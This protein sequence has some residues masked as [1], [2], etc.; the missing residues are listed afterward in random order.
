MSEETKPRGLFKRKRKPKDPNKAPGRLAQM[1][2]IFVMAQKQ[3]PQTAWLMGAAILGGAALGVLVGLI[4][5]AMWLWVILGILLGILGATWILGRFGESAAFM[6]LKGQTGAIGAVLNSV[7]RSWLLDEEPVAVDPKTQ[8]IVYRMTGKG[9]I[10]L[11]TEGPKGRTKKMLDKQVKRHERVAPGVT[12]HTIQAGEADGLVPMKDLRRTVE[13]LPK[14]LNKAEVLAV[15]KRLTALGGLT[16]NA[17]IPKGVDPTR[18]RPDH[19]AM[20]G[21]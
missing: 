6:Q 18:A 1:K 12:V 11:V 16:K 9:G 5:K 21:R 2:Q 8:D 15:R 4:F 17:P 14:Q 3:Y 20:R 19:K 13:K 7:K 10:V